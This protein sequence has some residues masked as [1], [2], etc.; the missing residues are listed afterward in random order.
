M[1]TVLIFWH[2]VILIY[3]KVN[4]VSG[5]IGP[6]VVCQV[7]SVVVYFVTTNV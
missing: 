2:V 5:N 7:N 6:N 4:S 1:N 3:Q